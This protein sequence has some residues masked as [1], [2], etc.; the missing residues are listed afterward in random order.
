M[1]RLTMLAL[2]TLLCA[3]MKVSAQLAVSITLRCDHAAADANPSPPNVHGA[4]YPATPEIGWKG[5]IAGAGALRLR[6][7]IRFGLRF[8]RCARL[9]LNWF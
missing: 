8:R 1:K 7:T 2:L 5:D 6:E 4:V 9:A 3:P